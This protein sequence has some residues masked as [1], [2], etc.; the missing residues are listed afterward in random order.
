[1]HSIEVV[2][3]RMRNSLTIIFFF[4]FATAFSQENEEEVYVWP[5]GP[6]AAIDSFAKTVEYKDDIRLLSYDLTKNYTTDLDKA[7]AIFIW[8]TDNVAYDYKLA[9]KKKSKRDSFK[10]KKGNCDIAY[11]KWEDNYLRKII[12]KKKGICSGYSKLFRKLCDHSGIQCSVVTGYTKDEPGQI[13][14]MG[15]L[16]HDWNAMLINGKYYY[17]DATWAAG[18]TSNDKN[19]KLN[20]F[21]KEYKEYYWLTPIEK[22]SRDHFPKDSVFIKYRNY[23]EAKEHYKNTAYIQSSLMDEIDITSPNSGIIEA[24]VGDTLY[25]EI[26]NT[27]LVTHIQAVSNL[28]NYKTPSEIR[29]SGKEWNEEEIKKQKYLPFKMVDDTYIF[30]VVVAKK[31]KYYDIM[32]NHNR[33]LRF[34]IN[35]LK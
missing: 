14:K 34:K 28:E 31:V 32:F 26:N 27:K 35:I 17:L 9:N 29:L 3:T 22:L 6:Y 4:I 25:F 33:A 23:A 15:I 7:R 30:T 18:G 10:C 12:T 13:G 19:G 21:R 2:L 24:K 11:A 8:I 16:D 1:L 5:K 20:G